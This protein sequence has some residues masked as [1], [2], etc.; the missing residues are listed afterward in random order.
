MNPIANNGSTLLGKAFV[1]VGLLFFAFGAVHATGDTSAATKRKCKEEFF[2]SP[3]MTGGTSPWCARVRAKVTES[4]SC[5]IKA[6]CWSMTVPGPNTKTQITVT[7][8]E[9]GRICLRDDGQLSL[10]SC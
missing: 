1:L 5:L 2:K 8:E 9:A 6:K 3:A 4:G 10:G 7:L